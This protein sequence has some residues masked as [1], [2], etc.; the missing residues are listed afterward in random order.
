M[1]QDSDSASPASLKRGGSLPT[2]IRSRPSIF[3][4][5]RQLSRTFENGKITLLC[6]FVTI[7]VLRGYTGLNLVSSDANA[8]NQNLIEESNQILAEI[9]SDSD[10]EENPYLLLVLILLTR[11]ALE[12]LIGTCSAGSGSGNI[13]ILR[14]TL[15]E[16][17]ES[18]LLRSHHLIVVIILSAIIIC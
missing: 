2:T 3:P 11:W 9:P 6:G 7:L 17:L 4:P 1:A 18:Y 14:V 16:N 13:R 8:V 5:R 12:L 10:P 15:R